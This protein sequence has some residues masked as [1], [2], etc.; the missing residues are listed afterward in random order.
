MNNVIYRIYISCRA[1][2]SC[3]QQ[4]ISCGQHDIFCSLQDI[5]CCPQD[6]THRT[7]PS[8]LKRF[9]SRGGISWSV[10]NILCILYPVDHNN[11]QDVKHVPQDVKCA[12]QDI[13]YRIYTTFLTRV[14]RRGRHPVGDIL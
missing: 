10:V 13:T 12:L 11:P 4:I 3:G 8:F 7:C 5:N 14:L 2:I 6:I 9:L 1:H